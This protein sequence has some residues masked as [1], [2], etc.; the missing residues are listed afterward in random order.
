MIVDSDK[1]IDILKEGI[2]L[3]KFRSLKSGKVYEREYTTHSSHM[4]IDF[5]QSASDKVI[6]YDVEFK[7]ME[8]IDISSIESYTPLEKLS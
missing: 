4:P 1:L 6:C 3:I 2:V 5:K 7:K 8:D